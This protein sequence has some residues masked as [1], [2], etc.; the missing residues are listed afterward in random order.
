MNIVN[1]VGIEIN[2]AIRDPYYRALLPFVAGLG[3]R[4]ANG[5]VKRINVIVGCSYFLWL[6]TLMSVR[7]CVR[8]VARSSAGQIS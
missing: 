3:P 5:M 8:A 7:M 1:I 4:K 6:C 2:R